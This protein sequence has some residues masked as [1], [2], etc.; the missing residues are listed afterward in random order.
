MRAGHGLTITTLLL[1]LLGAGACGKSK[2]SA[3]T[4]MP[5]PDGGMT[6]DVGTAVETGVLANCL[7]HPNDLPRPPGGQLPCELIPPRQ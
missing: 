6:V 4:P 1:A 5:T 7:D 3:V 2:P